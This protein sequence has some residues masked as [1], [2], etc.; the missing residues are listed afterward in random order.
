MQLE[1]QYLQ[2]TV[3]RVGTLMVP[4]EGALREKFFPALFG[5]EEINAAFQKILGYSVNHSGLGITYPPFSADSAYNTSKA[6]SRELVDS[7]IGGSALNCVGHRTCVRKASLA[8]RHAKMHVE[9]GELARRKELAGGQEKNRLHRETRNGA[10]LSDVPHRLNGMELYCE[11]FRD[12]IY[13]S[14]GLM[15]QDIPVI[16]DGCGKK[17]SIEHT[18]S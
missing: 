16:C 18:L 3:P 1:W 15:P 11:E 5:G 9:L 6:A 12:N 7:L 17:F 10:W 8:A 14:Y 4:I 13:L 2:S